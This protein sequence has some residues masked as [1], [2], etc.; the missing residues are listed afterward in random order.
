M[1]VVTKTLRSY[2]KWGFKP[3]K[4]LLDVLH[5]KEGEPRSPRV[6]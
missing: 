2:L 6:F 5:F 4:D 3:T 1:Q